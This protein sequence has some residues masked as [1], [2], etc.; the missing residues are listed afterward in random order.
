MVHHS[1]ASQ[2]FNKINNG[3]NWNAFEWD[4]GFESRHFNFQT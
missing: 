3:Q 4:L 1:Q 2:N